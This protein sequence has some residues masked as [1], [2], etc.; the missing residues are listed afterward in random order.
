[1]CLRVPVHSGLEELRTERL[2]NLVAKR[3]EQEED[4]GTRIPRQA[5]IGAVHDLAVGRSALIRA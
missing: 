1:M 4:T 3:V 2:G 5:A